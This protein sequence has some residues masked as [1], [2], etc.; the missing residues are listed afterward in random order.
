MGI[1]YVLQFF[2]IFVF[3]LLIISTF[4]LTVFWKMCVSTQVQDYHQCIDLTQFSKYTT[5][6]TWILHLINS[7]LNFWCEKNK[8]FCFRF[9]ISTI[10]PYWIFKDM[11]NSRNKVFLQRFCWKIRVYVYDGYFWC[12]FDID[13]FG[14]NY[15]FK[16]HEF[17]RKIK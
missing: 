5:S 17:P 9:P 13:K 6:I 2:W 4:I 16:V 12:N 8:N 15:L 1:I 3:G 10:Y 7:K 14:K 11:W